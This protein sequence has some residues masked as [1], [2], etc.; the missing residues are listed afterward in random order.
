MGQHVDAD[1]DY[2]RVKVLH[3][4]MDKVKSIL[5][6]CVREWGRDGD[7]E[8][9]QCF[10]HILDQLRKYLPINDHNI[11]KQR[12]LIPGSGLGR[13]VYDVAVAGY[14]AEG[15]EFSYQCLILGDFIM[16]RSTRPSTIYPWI[17][18]SSNA[19]S[20]QGM[21]ASA[22][23]PSFDIVEHLQNVN[24]G[25]QMCIRA[26]EFLREYE[27]RLDEHGTWDCIVTCFFSTLRRTSL[28]I[29]TSFTAC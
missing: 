26:G 21:L 9:R 11:N 28:S 15:I 22:E 19:K 14:Y 5:S 6:Q 29:W 10:G 8:R 23:I 24:P 17:H 13:L 18:A 7:T 16:N 4:N 25:A 27:K 2:A 3:R 1:T 20:L 12:V